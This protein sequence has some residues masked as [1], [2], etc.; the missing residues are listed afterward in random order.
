MT[1]GN[2]SAR[3]DRKAYVCISSRSSQLLEFQIIIAYLM[4]ILSIVVKYSVLQ[5][6]H[7]SAECIGMQL[8]CGVTWS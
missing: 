7:A 3:E 5:F 4:I 8:K 6:L 1:V 2:A